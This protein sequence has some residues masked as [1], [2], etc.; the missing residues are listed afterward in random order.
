MA[1]F[2]STISWTLVSIYVFNML[3]YYIWQGYLMRYEEELVPADFFSNRYRN[4]P[5]LPVVQIFAVMI[6]LLMFSVTTI[7]DTA[8]S[9]FAA[10]VSGVLVQGMICMNY[11]AAKNSMASG[12]YVGFLYITVGCGLVLLFAVA[13][14]AL[15]AMFLSTEWC[16]LISAFLYFVAAYAWGKLLEW[17]PIRPYYKPAELEIRLWGYVLVR[18]VPVHS[19]ITGIVFGCHTL[20]ELDHYGLAFGLSFYVTSFSLLLGCCF[21]Y[22]H[23]EL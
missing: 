11:L 19:L 4:Y 18:S 9:G 17:T 12:L 10:L 23:E 3:V 14:T 16:G 1:D 22:A 6:L 20:T 2:N 8:T 13:S 15:T 5:P 7:F 21:V